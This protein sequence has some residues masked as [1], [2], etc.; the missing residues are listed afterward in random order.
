MLNLL[1]L[2]IHLLTPIF[3]ELWKST[4]PERCCPTSQL[5][6]G[7]TCC[8]LLQPVSL[9]A[10]QGDHIEDRYLPNIKLLPESN[11]FHAYSPEII[12]QS[13]LL[14]AKQQPYQHRYNLIFS[15]QRLYESLKPMHL[16]LSLYYLHET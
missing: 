5:R 7:L 3:Y 10:I 13:A 9:Q 4:I 14:P 11:E 6:L 15:T 1:A 8:R 2:G 12:L 16:Q